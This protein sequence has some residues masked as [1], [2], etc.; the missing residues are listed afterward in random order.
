MRGISLL[1]AGLVA[2]TA[3][4]DSGPTTPAAPYPALSGT[5]N[6]TVSLPGSN[7]QSGSGPV[8][9]VQASRDT[10][11][12]SIGW[13]VTGFSAVSALGT[14]STTG[15]V[16]ID[17][18]LNEVLHLKLSGQLSADGRTVT[19]TVVEPSPAPGIVPTL[20]GTFTM[21]KQ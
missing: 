9:F 16:A 8:T 21:K 14:V 19:G 15:V 20:N 3:C 7:A 6:T 11:T 18:D 17:V 1:L 4:G 13:L 2:A 12:L 5:F 10:S